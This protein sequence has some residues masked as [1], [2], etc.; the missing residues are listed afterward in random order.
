M[1]TT[2]EKAALAEAEKVAPEKRKALGRGLESLLPGGPRV[3]AGAAAGQAVA[4][5]VAPHGIVP[6]EIHAQA[7]AASGDA[8]VQIGLAEIE[9]NPYQTRYHFDGDAL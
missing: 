5:E 8:V 9:H 1:T 6:P 4:A 2:M 3:V 7:R